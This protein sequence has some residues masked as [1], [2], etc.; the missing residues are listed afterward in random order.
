MYVVDL[1]RLLNAFVDCRF[2]LIGS[3]FNAFVDC[4]FLCSQC[5]HSHILCKLVSH[6]FASIM[7]NLYI[8]LLPLT[9]KA[10]IFPFTPFDLWKTCLCSY[11]KEKVSH[12]YSMQTLDITASL[13]NVDDVGHHRLKGKLCQI[14]S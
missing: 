14:K 10:C 13:Q 2:A 7:I 12:N 8:D 5:I 11:L 9:I 1:D 3:L 4:R 6:W